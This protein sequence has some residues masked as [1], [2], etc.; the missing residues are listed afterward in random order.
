MNTSSDHLIAQA[1]ERFSLQDYYG[2]IHLLSE[3][4][5]MGRDFADVYHLRG[6]SYSLLGQHERALEEFEA[7]LKLNE[8]YIEAHIHR[9]IVLGELGRSDEAHEAFQQ[10]A[11]HSDVDGELPS[12]IAGRLANQHADLA[13]S[14]A[15]VGALAV[16]I[17]QY[18]RALELCG[19]FH[20]LRYRL[21]RLLLEA[22]Q[23]LDA[24][25]ELEQIVAARPNFVDAQAALGLARYLSGDANGAKDIWIACREQRPK[26]ARIEAY[27][28]MLER[29][30]S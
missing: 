6:L 2:A 13:A 3:V 4:I 12:H 5:D 7:A 24:R 25:T 30:V 18:R 1:Q 28:A 20:D 15:E 19:D 23:V 8:R 29:T 11:T 17:G 14:Y 10:A 21:A 27:L 16:A 22:G 9:G 26:N